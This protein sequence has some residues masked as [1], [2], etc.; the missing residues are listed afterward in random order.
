M[1]YL[2]LQAYGKPTILQEALFNL[3]TFWKLKQA[4]NYEVEIVVYT[5]QPAYY[6][7]FSSKIHI[8]VLTPE[9][10]QAWKGAKQFVHRLKIMMLQDFFEKYKADVLYVDS[11]T[12]FLKDCSAL[13]AAINQQTSVMHIKES[14]LQE[15][16]NLL[17]KKIYKFAKKNTFLI[18]HETIKIPLDTPMWNAGVLGIAYENRNLLNNVVLLTDVMYDKY[19][20]HVMEQLAFSYILNKH[21][22]ILPADEYVYHYWQAGG[23]LGDTIADFFELYKDLP[24]EEL[25]YKAYDYRFEYILSPKKSFFRKTL[26]KITKRVGNNK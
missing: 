9:K 4:G 26:Q 24:L 23:K 5:D 17:L 12:Y 1:Q 21:T 13:F 3:L 7:L 6:Q 22:A 10:I 8:E 15:K 14:L 18:D 2:L 11:D 16:E 20:K 19:P 25:A